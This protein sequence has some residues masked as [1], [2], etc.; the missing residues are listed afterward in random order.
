MAAMTFNLDD[1]RTPL[2]NFPE[3]I[4]EATV[5]DAEDG[6]SKALNNQIV[7]QLEITHPEFG[8]INMKD[9]LS[10][11][12]PSKVAAFIGAVSGMTLNELKEEYG[13]NLTVDS[14]T[15][16]GQT[17]LVVLGSREYTDDEGN[18]RIT[19]QIVAPWYYNVA[20]QDL[21]GPR[22]RSEDVPF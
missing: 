14:A 4:Y 9:F 17:C 7:T 6:V 21:I 5:I 8:V 15:L 16:I 1:V 11:K 3:G 18:Q 20:R 2:T 22:V 10:E 19:R 12:M 13:N